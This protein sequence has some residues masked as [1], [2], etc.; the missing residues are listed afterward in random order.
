M[1]GVMSLA[2]GRSHDLQVGV[3][4]ETLGFG[5]AVLGAPVV[6][7]LEG[8]D[9]VRVTPRTLGLGDRVLGAP[10]IV[11]TRAGTSGGMGPGCG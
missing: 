4:L 6:G 5:Q 3:T 8:R 7:G 9:E 2:L 11:G 1:G 10:I